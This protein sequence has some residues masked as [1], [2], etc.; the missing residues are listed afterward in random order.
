MTEN[1]NILKPN[2]R[3]LASYGTFIFV[4][5]VSRYHPASSHRL[6]KVYKIRTLNS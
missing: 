5:K 3:N 4:K 1:F 6:T 2:Y